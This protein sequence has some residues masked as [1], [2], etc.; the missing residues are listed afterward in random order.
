ME[1]ETKEQILI[2][3]LKAI[4][5]WNTLSSEEYDKIYPGVFRGWLGS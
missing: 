3:G 2:R 4:E 5:G 1:Q